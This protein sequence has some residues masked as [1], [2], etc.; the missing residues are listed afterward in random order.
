MS[1]HFEHDYA[2]NIIIIKEKE[3]EEEERFKYFEKCNIKK[4]CDKEEF[5]HFLFNVFKDF[6]ITRNI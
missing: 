1:F 3:K 6:R 5:Q 4:Y 2:K